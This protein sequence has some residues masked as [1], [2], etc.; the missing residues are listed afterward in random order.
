[1]PLVAV[2]CSSLANHM[3]KHDMCYFGEV[4]C[5]EIG[6]PAVERRAIG[7]SNRQE[8]TAISLRRQVG[9]AVASF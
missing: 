4:V 1:M 6:R 3:G 5:A 9:M 7:Q 2:H 8:W